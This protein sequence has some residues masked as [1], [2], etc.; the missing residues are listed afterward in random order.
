MV[1]SLHVYERFEHYKPR[2]VG[3][4]D[5]ISGPK[6]VHFDRVEWHVNPDQTSVITALQTAELDWDEWRLEDALPML[7]RN[8]EVAV[9]KIGSVGWWGLMRPNHLFPPFDKPEVRRA[10]MGAINQRDFM[11]A[12][13]GSDPA[14]W[15]VPTGYFP[16]SSPMA[17]DVGLDALTRTRSLD[18]VGQDLQAAGYRGE[19]IVLM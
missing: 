15:H 11:S 5:F 17:S 19:K 8:S 10:L 18:K 6:I 12:A 9:K 1:G 4:V 3:A 13:I 16:P 14:L 7:R 2:E